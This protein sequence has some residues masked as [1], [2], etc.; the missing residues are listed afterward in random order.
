[1]KRDD[2]FLRDVQLGI[3]GLF[4]GALLA[5]CVATSSDLPV[6]TDEVDAATPTSEDLAP[7]DLAQP[8][9]LPPAPRCTGKGAMTA[10]T[11]TLKMMSRGKERTYLLH[12]PTGYDPTKPSSL[13]LAFHGMSDKA[14]DFFKMIDLGKEADKR[15]LI[16]I[17]PQGLGI[18]A[19]W[20]AGNCCGEPQLFKVDDVGFVSDLIDSAKRD[21]CIDDKRI[22]AMGFSNGGMF[23]HRLAC[24]LSSVFSAVGPVAGTLMF[25]ACKPDRP[26]SILHLH[27][28]ADPVVGYGGG[29]SG[30]F[31]KVSEVIADWARRDSCMGMAQQT[32]KSGAVTCDTYRTCAESSEVSLCTIDQGKHTWPGAGDGNKDL[33]ATA[34]L[35]DFFA[36]HSR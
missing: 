9:L 7:P 29:G 8:D 2:Q 23:T 20:N 14:P 22:Y 11:T 31:P 12:I 4:G 27:G 30:S 1:M 17:I 28:N 5:G 13:V 35:L 16:G 36:K 32:Y 33:S 19:G 24:E 18:I 6:L 15:N 25:P 21:L 26:V 10:G 34:A 3:L